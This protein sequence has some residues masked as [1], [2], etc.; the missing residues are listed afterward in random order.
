MRVLLST[1]L[2]FS[3]LTLPS[4]LKASSQSVYDFS[5]LDPDKEVY[6]LQNRKYRKSGRIHAYAG[7][8]KTLSGAF[9]DAIT[10]QGRVGYFLSENWGVEFVYANNNG[11]ENSTAELLRSID[12]QGGGARPFRR[13]VDDYMGGMLMWSPFYSKINT[14]NKILYFDWMIGLGVAKLEETNNKIEIQRQT[15]SAE[16]TTES[17]T[18]IMWNL[19][20]KFFI[21]HTW[22]LR[23][24]LTAL[25][26]KADG[27]QTTNPES[28]W[29]SNFDLSFMFGFNF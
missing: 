18:A 10:L 12:P 22:S 6:V 8:G 29:N 26:Y 21:N 11:S 24:D 13:I 28:S 9:V 16:T 4:I 23:T 14:F 19:G 5:W 27:P 2:F 3:C 7:G 17:H 25:H 20:V 15:D 1:L